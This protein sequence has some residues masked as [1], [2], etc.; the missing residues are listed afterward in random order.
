MISSIPSQKLGMA[1]PT[2]ERMLESVSH[3]LL[4]YTA[5][6]MPSGTAMMIAT[7]I[8][9]MANSIVAGKRCTTLSTIGEPVKSKLPKSPCSTPHSQS[10][11][12]M[13][14]GLFRPIASRAA[15][16]S[17]SVANSPPATIAASPGSALSSRNR[18]MLTVMTM[19]IIISSFLTILAATIISPF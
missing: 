11:Y 5:E 14:S 4:R 1:I 3:T 8:E 16:I 19:G 10:K 12:C 18:M 15:S 2:T 13:Y 6:M 7:I 9:R 17:A